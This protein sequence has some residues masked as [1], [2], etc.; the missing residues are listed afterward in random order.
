VPVTDGLLPGGLGWAF[1][2][3]LE[4]ANFGGLDVTEWILKGEAN[5]EWC[6]FDHAYFDPVYF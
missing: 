4:H 6:Y 3:V 5:Q 1:G 2:A